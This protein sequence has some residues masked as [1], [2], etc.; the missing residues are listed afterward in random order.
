MSRFV[1]L[2]FPSVTLLAILTLVTA[3]GITGE[4]VA[5]MSFKNISTQDSLYIEYSTLE[6]KAGDKVNLWTEMNLEYEGSLGLEYRL[7]VLKDSD[8]L[9]TLQLNP[10]ERDISMGEVKTEFGNK[11]RWK[12]SG[13]MDRLDIEE[14][15][16]YEFKGILVSSENPTLQLKT[17]ELVLKQ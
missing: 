3:C 17:A 11:T 10:F 9:G 4:E 14:D 8:T 12:F 16:S 7:M 1:K 13:R 6:L 15:G 2:T 5:R